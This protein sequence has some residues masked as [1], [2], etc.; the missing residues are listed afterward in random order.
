VLSRE[1][2]CIIDARFEPMQKAP[3][4]IVLATESGQQRQVNVNRQPWLPPTVG[5]QRRR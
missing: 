4:E 2:T 3:D 1:L 5:G